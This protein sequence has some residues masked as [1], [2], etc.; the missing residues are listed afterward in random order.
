MCVCVCLCLH[1]S[2]SRY[3]SLRV[4]AFIRERWSRTKVNCLAGSQAGYISELLCL[5]I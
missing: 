2:V 3:K 1:V 5:R 4:Y